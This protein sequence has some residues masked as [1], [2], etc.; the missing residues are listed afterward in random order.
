MLLPCMHP[1]TYESGAGATACCAANVA[2][3]C[4]CM[5]CRANWML[6]MRLPLKPVTSGELLAKE[7]HEVHV[8]QL[9]AVRTLNCR[10][11]SAERVVRAPQR[12]ACTRKFREHVTVHAKWCAIF[13][14]V[15]HTSQS[16]HKRLEHHAASEAVAT[17][18]PSRHKPSGPMQFLRRS[19]DSC[20]VY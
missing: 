5:S 15:L 11:W 1:L 18:V 7:C 2:P 14:I 19:R 12:Y 20:V 16:H 9:Q 17:A 6:L 13:S 8:Q 10:R 3:T 4:A